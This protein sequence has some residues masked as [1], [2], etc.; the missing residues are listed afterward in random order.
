RRLQASDRVLDEEFAAILGDKIEMDRLGNPS[1]FTC[2]DC[3]GTLWEIDDQGLLEFRCRV[4]HSFTSDGVLAAHRAAVEASLWAAVKSLEED[5]DLSRRLAER[6]PPDSRS[7]RHLLSG[8]AE[9]EAHA[10]RLRELI[11]TAAREEVGEEPPRRHSAS[12]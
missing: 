6:V 7:R 10:R 5:A 2:P 12:N 1:R 4:G 11:E 8:V 3:Q 9:K